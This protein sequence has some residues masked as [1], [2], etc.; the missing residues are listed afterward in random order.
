MY[1]QDEGGYPPME[2]LVMKHLPLPPCLLAGGRL[3]RQQHTR[4]PPSR[5]RR[6]LRH[7]SRSPVCRVLL[8][9][10]PAGGG[11]VLGPPCGLPPYDGEWLCGSY[12]YNDTGMATWTQETFGSMPD[13][14]DDTEGA[15]WYFGG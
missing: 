9:Q 12:A 6:C 4:R 3:R 13:G 8:P 1:A 15:F 14:L 11:Y 7:R 2:S 10:L 5:P